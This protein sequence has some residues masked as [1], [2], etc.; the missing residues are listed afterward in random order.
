CHRTCTAA[1]P[2]DIKAPVQYGKNFRALLSYL[3]DV[4]EEA[5]LRRW[6]S[7][8]LGLFPNCS[9]RTFISSRR[10]WMT[11]CWFRFSQPA[12][13]MSSNSSAFTWL[14]SMD[15]TYRARSEVRRCSISPALLSPNQMRVSGHYGVQG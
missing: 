9:F 8:N 3:Y 13:Q 12:T 5:S 1:F 15:Q 4:Q 6:S 14:S 10:Y 2:S 11:S 7:L